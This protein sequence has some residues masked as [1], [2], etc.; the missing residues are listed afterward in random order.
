MRIRH[1]YNFVPFAP[2]P[3]REP[4][5][6]AANHE[7]FR[8]DLHA[9]TLHCTLETLS[10]LC[11]RPHFEELRARPLETYL[12]ASSLKGMARSMAQTLGAG[13]A[14]LFPDNTKDPKYK[15][16][17]RDWEQNG[18]RGPRPLARRPIPADL[19]GF[20][21]CTQAE[22]C[23]VCRVFGYAP[24]K[25]AE[26]G[27]PPSGWAGKVRFHDSAQVRNWDGDWVQ[28]P[29]GNARWQAQGAYHAPFYFPDFPTSKRPA[30]WKV[31][32]HAKHVTGAAADFRP[33]ECVPEGVFFDFD[34]EY[35]N[36][37]DEE[38]AVLR[39]AL[40][41]R[42][43]CADRSV[44]LAHKLGYGKGIGM[45]SCRVT[46]EVAPLRVRRFF[47]ESPQAGKDPGCEIHRHLDLP[48]FAA[49]RE[50]LAWEYR[51]DQVLF[52][53]YG[54]FTGPGSAKLIRDYETS[55][56]RQAAP[57]PLPEPEPEPIP[58]VKFP[59]RVEVRITEVT[60]KGVIRF[61]TVAPIGGITYTGTA[62]NPLPGAAVGRVCELKAGE[63]DPVKKIVTGR[64][65]W[66]LK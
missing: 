46:A 5:A 20:E 40:T 42:H 3:E 21:P 2:P 6:R 33:G 30:G 19:S 27:D 62:S 14:S 11:I 41:L 51:P 48:G 26:Q 47:G 59:N 64:V 22:A 66:K 36:L 32:L 44:S 58:K 45:G 29:P 37:S 38:F 15:R 17:V 50:F 54:W 61:E 56:N 18:S 31:Y 63:A 4:M 49:L 53:D 35:E 43:E 60:K 23:L 34:V 57:A 16:A 52:P 10:M 55:I 13:C 1:P 8:S 65:L 24:A 39:F 12:P 25:D 9:G 28:P 7:R